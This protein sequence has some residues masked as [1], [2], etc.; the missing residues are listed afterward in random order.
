MVFG[1]LNGLLKNVLS[2]QSDIISFYKGFMS[3]PISIFRN[4]PKI[5]RLF[6][7]CPDYGTILRDKNHFAFDENILSHSN[8]PLHVKRII[9]FL[10]FLLWCFRNKVPVND[11]RYHFQWY[12]KYI[13]LKSDHP[14]D[15]TEAVWAASVNDSIKSSF[16]SLLL[17]D[18]FFRRTKR[19]NWEI[20]WRRGKLIDQKRPKEIIAF[21]FQESKK[22]KK[23]TIEDPYPD[24]DSFKI[25]PNG[26]RNG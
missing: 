1:N 7:D 9:H 10:P 20:S 11:L 12:Y 5:T 21:H 14:R 6:Q 2:G 13:S 24:L 26:I 17:T 16:N 19:K 18:P 3:G 4:T 23:F 8:R 25:L 15:F 22:S